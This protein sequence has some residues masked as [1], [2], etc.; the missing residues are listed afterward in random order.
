MLALASPLPLVLPCPL[1]LVL[2]PDRCAQDLLLLLYVPVA[3]VDVD[4]VSVQPPGRD[5][6][7][8][9]QPQ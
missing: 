1:P 2:D 6:S 5:V 9:T 8:G 7:L 4:A 3:L